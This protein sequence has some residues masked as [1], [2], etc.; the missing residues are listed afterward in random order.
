MINLNSP[1]SQIK[2]IGPKKQKI[3]DKLEVFTVE[4]LLYYFPRTYEDRRNKVKIIDLQEGVPAVIEGEVMSKESPPARH[5][6]KAPFKLLIKDETQI[7]EIVFFKANYMNNIFKVGGKYIF[8][9]TP[10]RNYNRFQLIHPDFKAAEEGYGPEI[11]P[12]YPLTEGLGQRDIRKW[13]E[14]LVPF[15]DEIHEYIPESTIKRNNLC[16]ISHALKNIHFPENSTRYKEARYRLIFEELLELQL[17][18]NLLKNKKNTLK[19]GI[20]F[21]KDIDLSVFTSTL[22]FEL[23]G[24]QKRVVKEIINDMEC[25]KPMNRLVQGDVGSGKTIVAAIA[26]YKAAKSHYQSVMM[27]PTEILAAQH[28]EEI[29]GLFTGLNI[30][31]G[32]LSGSIKKKERD[33]TLER[34]RNGEIDIIIGTHALIQEDVI[35]KKLGLAITDEQHRFG[36]K[37]RVSLSEKGSNADVLV[38]T[39]TPIPRTLAFILYG[40]LDISVID[41]MPPGR[42]K[43]T[44]KYITEKERPVAFDFIKKQIEK[45]R[46]AYV[47]APLIEDSDVLEQLKSAETLYKDLQKIFKGVNLALLHGGMKQNEKDHIMERFYTGDIQILISTVVIEVGINVKNATVMVIEN[48]ERFGLAQLHQLRGRV[49]RGEHKSYCI[50]IS[51][52]KTEEAKERLELMTN[53]DNG[54]EIS[55]K[56]LQMRGPG[57]LFGSKQHG[58]P[59]LKLSDLI[60]NVNI[61]ETIKSEAKQ[62]LAED[63]DLTKPENIKLKKHIQN[64]FGETAKIGL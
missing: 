41:E 25:S 18:L 19:D 3:L 51:D 16:G 30:T 60:K 32:F 2:G 59:S 29:N 21:N 56:D 64:L 31:V 28:Y 33:E 44:T 42:Q 7:L 9:G 40:D 50:L 15:V 46:Q 14:Q 26:M 62:L 4:D 48:A 54:F 34:L 43:I 23:T 24:A 20:P 12:V 55:E 45:G 47:V 8:F 63:P 61:F 52:S 58:I 5:R 38:M 49:G 13:Q 22:K 57:D 11:L 53:T 35:Y 17:G 36:V 39:A 10:V 37:Q 6:G 27:A 1:V